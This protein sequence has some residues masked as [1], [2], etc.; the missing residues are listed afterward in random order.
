M[1][2]LNSKDKFIATEPINQ[3]GEWGEQQ[4]WNGICQAFA[5]RNCI[6]YWRYPIFSASEGLR[7][8]ADILILDAE[9]GIIIIEVKSIHID[10]IVAIAGHR[11]QLQNFYT[12]QINPY[13][14]AEQQLFALFNFLQL[15]IALK[16]K[17]QGRVLVAL[18]CITQQQWQQ[19]GFDQL[20]SCPPI[21]FQDSI[22]SEMDLIQTLKQTPTVV[23]GHPLSS[24]HWNLLKSILTGTPLFQP[25]TRQFFLNAA[26][27]QSETM[28]RSAILAQ[29]RSVL[30]Q[31][32]LQ[33]EKIGKQI[34]PG[35]QRIR[36][37]AGSGK[38]VLLCQK[39]AFMH[40]KYPDWKIAIVFFTRSL[41][42]PITQQLDRW[43]RHFTGGRL[44]YFSDS[45]NLQVLHA[46]GSKQQPGFYSF[47]CKLHDFN[48][49]TVDSQSRLTPNQK[50]AVLCTQL[51]KKINLS[52]YFD[53]ILIDE[54]QDLLVDDA[55]KFEGKQPF[56]WMAYQSLKTIPYLD[57]K[58][59]NL[60][61]KRL[62]W[63]GDST[64]SLTSTKIA[65]AR[66]LFGEN[67]SHLVW[68]QYANG[69]NKTELM[70]RCYRTPEFIF[71]VAQGISMGLLRP[72]G[73]LMGF[74]CAADWEALGYQVKTHRG[75]FQPGE[76]VTVEYVSNPPQHPI[77]NLWHQPL[78]Q[79]KVYPSR[80]AELTALAENILHNLKVDGLRP[81]REI[82]VII[83]GASYQAIFLEKAVAQALMQQGIDIFIPGA[84]D[85][86]CLDFN[87]QAANPNQFWCEGGVTISRINRA[88]GN[89][90]DMVYLVGL[91]RIASQEHHLYFRQQLFIGF[92][93]SRGWVH[94]SGI[95]SYPFYHELWRVMKRQGHFTF[96]HHNHLKKILSSISVSEI[97]QQYQ[98]GDRHFSRVDFSRMNLSGINLEKANLMGANFSQ[99]QLMG[100]NFQQSK[101]MIANFTQ[102]ELSYANFSQAKLVGVTFNQAYLNGANFHQADL[103]NADLRN[104]QL[105]GAYLETANLDGADL[106]GAILPDSLANK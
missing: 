94:L 43:L 89:E 87:P 40:L 3:A 29:I 91:D 104:T 35:P 62:I 18:P 52:P 80:P 78:I 71:T 30:A 90:A 14:Q 95:G 36:G 32:D 99:A 24:Q 34:P 39:A 58:P 23:S 67:H 20:P 1:V 26:K 55:L 73:L 45:S 31:L 56:F 102:A 12:T 4:V 100:A 101:L 70:T 28:P 8:E 106:K 86:N 97:L 60:S 105:I 47:L 84:P 16:N 64:Q 75:Q 59:S 93:R 68:G 88:K 69:I 54:S 21:L 76:K 98:N 37:V 17:V 11:W 15:E 66:E 2:D 7:R 41:Y 72:Q 50:L 6:A 92:T 63:A 83:L 13:Q 77:S 42:D 44:K 79:F 25:P 81:S 10:Q 65:T 38:T 27:H 5:Q 103:R 74:N 61:L 53:A 85:C 96:T 19:R 82:L 49:E 22:E 46:W 57:H 33:Q 48:P 9:L 51:L